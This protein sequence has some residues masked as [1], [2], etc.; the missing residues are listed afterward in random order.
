MEKCNRIY[1]H[2]LY[3]DRM[4]R[5][6]N[7][8]RDRKFCPHNLA[9]ALDVA[10]IGWITILERRLEIDK[11][12]FYAA[13]L[14]HDAGR[15]SGI[16]HN[17]SGARL[18]EKIMPECGF[19]AEET[20]LTADAIRGHRTKRNGTDFASVLSA[21]DKASRMCFDCRAADECY[22]SDEKRNT[23]IDV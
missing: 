10:R 17:E 13:A 11:E 4:N 23:R 9:H 6:E 20:A 1:N 15:Y 18:A 7:A 12:L 2:P 19:S 16:P 21:A 14:L 5:I 3:R 22:W 8:E